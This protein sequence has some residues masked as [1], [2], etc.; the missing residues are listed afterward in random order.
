MKFKI[1]Y[2]FF[3]FIGFSFVAYGNGLKSGKGAVGSS[4]FL[5]ANQGNLQ[6]K[7]GGFSYAWEL[8]PG[9]TYSGWI[10]FWSNGGT[11]T[12]DFQMMPQVSWMTVS[13]LDFTTTG[14]NDIVQMVCSFTAPSTPGIY[15]TI[16]RDMNGNWADVNIQLT[17][18]EHP[19]IDDSLR[20]QL[21]PGQSATI[22]LDTLSWQGFSNLGCFTTYVPGQVILVDIT[23]NPAAPWLTVQPTSYSLSLNESEIVEATV[24]G[25]TTGNLYTYLM[26]TKTWWTLPKYYLIELDTVPDA[27]I[28]I[29]NTSGKATR[30]AASADTIRWVADRVDSVS[31]YFS[32]DATDSLATFTTIE[33]AWPAE[34][35]MYIWTL[36]DTLSRKCVISIEASDDPSVVANSDTFGIKPYVLTRVDANGDYET[37]SI[38]Q[39]AWQFRNDS[40]SVW[41][42]SWW[43][44]FDY[45]TATDPNTGIGYPQAFP[46]FPIYAEAND[47]PDWPLLTDVYGLN[48]CYLSVPEARYS[49]EA[50]L[51]WKVHGGEWLGSCFGFAASSLIAFSDKT[52]FFSMFPFIPNFSDLRTLAANVEERKAINHLFISQFGKRFQTQRRTVGGQPPSQTIADLKKMFLEEEENPRFLLLYSNDPHQTGAHAVLPYKLEAHETLPNRYWIYVYDNNAPNNFTLRFL[53]NTEVDIWSYSRY[54]RWGG[55][56]GIFLS[57]PISDYYGDFDFRKNGSKNSINKI[58]NGRVVIYQSDSLHI[59]IRNSSGQIISY[60]DSVL[61]N[62]ISDAQAFIPVTGYPHPPTGFEL[63]AGE[64]DINLSNFRDSNTYLS[65]FDDSLRY[66]YNRDDAAGNQQDQLSFR[67][68]FSFANPDGQSK[69]VSLRTILVEENRE[70]LVDIK[71]LTV[72]QD[73]SL[74]TNFSANG[75]Y[76]LRNFGDDSSYDLRLVLVSDSEDALFIHNNITLPPNSSHII[77]P[78]W[79][80]LL[81]QSLQILIDEGNDGTIDDSITVVNQPTS[82][83]ENNPA[84]GHLPQAFTLAQ[85]YPNPFNPTTSIAFTL[86]KTTT[87]TLAVFNSLG[88]QVAVL[89]E[90][91]YPAGHHAI[92]FNAENLVSGIYFYRLQGEGFVKTRKMLLIR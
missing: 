80:D 41:P 43:Q 17:V 46:T 2:L 50:L 75:E 88:Q 11:L 73:D 16:L 51:F 31:I 58:E 27:S 49:P 44:Q 84:T 54:P 34:T 56:R 81:N 71:N 15:S 20:F 14:C 85:N 30:L 22:N 7:S 78:D 57:N 28:S 87:I 77:Q 59:N 26:E 19:T 33:P 52:E 48:D 4:D 29:I 5:I 37:F 42:Q 89:A 55:S 66:H 21:D 13:P 62:E 9:Q 64:Y 60:I 92:D 24:T 91:T 38:A 32:A 72:G 1:M 18:T 3:C 83:N 82:I 36:P 79:E 69:N 39:D 76:Q 53:V 8:F 10:Y 61:Q 65:I 45:A 63:P 47:F 68:G 35:G 70:R 23:E 86:P 67:E 74:N 12:A 25:D 6:S 40:S 90:G